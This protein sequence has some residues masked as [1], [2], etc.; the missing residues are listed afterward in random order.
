M[1]NWTWSLLARLAHDVV[2]PTG[3]GCRD[4]RDTRCSG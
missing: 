4:G 3:M 2:A 1:R